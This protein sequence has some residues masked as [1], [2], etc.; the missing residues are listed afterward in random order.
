MQGKG[1]DLLEE[2]YAAR[3]ARDGVEFDPLI[4]IAIIGMLVQV[5]Q[6]CFQRSPQAM[7]RRLLNRARLAVGLRERMPNLMWV[8]AFRQA[9]LLFDMA[10]EATDDEL[11]LL[12]TDCCN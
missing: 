4:I 1:F 6:G 11:Q 7:R 9:D 10:D 8:E 2:R 12:I 5:I 3:A